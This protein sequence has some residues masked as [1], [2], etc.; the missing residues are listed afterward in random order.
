MQLPT[1]DFDTPVDK[2]IH[3]WNWF[4]KACALNWLT[5]DDT[6]PQQISFG[7]DW[8]LYRWIGNLSAVPLGFLFHQLT[9]HCC[10]SFTNW[11]RPRQQNYTGLEK[12]LIVYTSCR[13]AGSSSAFQEQFFKACNVPAISAFTNMSTMKWSIYIISHT[14]LVTA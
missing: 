6:C 8:H 5:A 10:I 4:E 13:H 1:L 3:T 11:L 12:R 2:F 9:K 14:S 7:N